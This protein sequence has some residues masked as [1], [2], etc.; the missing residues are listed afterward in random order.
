[1]PLPMRTVLKQ[2]YL[3]AL[4]WISADA[5]LSKIHLKISEAFETR[6]ADVYDIDR[7]ENLENS[8]VL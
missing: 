1:L 5:E 8:R 7:T 4:A 6:Q 3:Q 2:S